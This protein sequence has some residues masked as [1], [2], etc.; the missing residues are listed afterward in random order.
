MATAIHAK[1]FAEAFNSVTICSANF[2]LDIATDAAEKTTSCDTA[3]TFTPGKYGWTASDG[4]PTDFADNG[5]DETIFNAITAGT[6]ATLSFKPDGDS[7]TSATNPSYSGSAFP[8]SYSIAA[9][10]GNVVQASTSFQGTGAL[11]R[12]VA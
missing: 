7:S 11:A 1:K 2:S 3:K 9:D 10:I 4:G 12:A 5:Q 6:T 8:T